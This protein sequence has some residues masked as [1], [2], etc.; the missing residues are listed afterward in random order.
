M[1]GAGT[2]TEMKELE[3]ITLFVEDLAGSK[4]FYLEI[5]DAK[6][7]YEDPVSVV[8]KLESVMINLLRISEAPGLIVPAKVADSSAG[9]RLMFTVRVPN[10]DEVCGKLKTLGVQLLNGP[11]DR[12]WG[13][14]TAAFADPAGHIWELAHEI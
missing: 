6:I 5:F 9:Q 1:M 2:I 4:K 8:F 7:A 14:R 11:L 3:C 10:V 13:R 12:P